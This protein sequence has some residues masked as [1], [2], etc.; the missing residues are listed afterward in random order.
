[1][2]EDIPAG[3]KISLRT[4]EPGEPVVKYGF[5]IGE[6][7]AR[8]APGAWVHTHN[9]KTRLEGLVE[10]RYEPFDRTRKSERET[11][12]GRSD[13]RVPSSAFFRGY[14]RRNGRVGTRKRGVDPQHGRLRQPRGRADCA[15]G[16]GAVRRAG[17]GG[18]DRRGL[19]F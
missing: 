6:V 9:L 14:R 3:H 17:A 12:N 15:G 13:F 8:I 1:L 4:L 10:Y 2:R 16:S 18:L 7:T 11:R 19:R 5:P